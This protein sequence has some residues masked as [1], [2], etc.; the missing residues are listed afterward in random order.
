MLLDQPTS[1]GVCV[2]CNF[3]DN[4]SAPTY[5]VA[6]VHQ[7]ISQLSSSGLMNIESSH[8]FNRSGD[9]AYG[10]ID[11]IS[12]E[13]Y[14]VEV[15]GGKFKMIMEPVPKSETDH[16]FYCTQVFTILLSSSRQSKRIFYSWSHHRRYMYW[17]C[18]ILEMIL[19][20]SCWLR[21]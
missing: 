10:C 2:T 14:Q 5:C 16:Y 12:L 17:Y 19:K 3:M 9:T 13:Q 1:S 6:V 4:T 11:G 15:I 20:W 21:K 18:M 8:K 7:R